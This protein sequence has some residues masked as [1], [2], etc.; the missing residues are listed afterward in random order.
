VVVGALVVA[1]DFTVVVVASGLTG[2]QIWALHWAWP[3]KAEAHTLRGEA[4]TRK[5]EPS[6]D[7]FAD[8]PVVWLAD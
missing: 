1:V 3:A 6:L 7:C 5:S 8:C 4:F 2:A